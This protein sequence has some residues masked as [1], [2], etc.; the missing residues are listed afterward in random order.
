MTDGLALPPWVHSLV[1]EGHWKRKDA[2]PE[3]WGGTTGVIR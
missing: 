1:A 3:G 2:P